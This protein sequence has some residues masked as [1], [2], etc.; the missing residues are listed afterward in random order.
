MEMLWSYMLEDYRERTRKDVYEG[1]RQRAEG[2][3]ITDV[4][5]DV[6]LDE[7]TPAPPGLDRSA[8]KYWAKDSLGLFTT[9]EVPS[10]RGEA[11][12]VGA[13]LSNAIQT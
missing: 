12:F 10:T 4:P 9:A 8:P 11:A 5:V 6:W 13:V 3:V 7:C 1:N 2:Q